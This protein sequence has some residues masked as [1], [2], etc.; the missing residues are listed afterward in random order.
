[1]SGQCSI[2]EEVAAQLVGLIQKECASCVIQEKTGGDVS[3]FV[4]GLLLGQLSVIIVIAFV[5]RY[6]FL[7]DVH[8]GK[9]ASSV[10]VLHYYTFLCL[11]IAIPFSYA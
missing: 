4:K 8:Q 9:K 11:H 1:M 10:M 2:Y 7:E 5:L 3:V 6:M